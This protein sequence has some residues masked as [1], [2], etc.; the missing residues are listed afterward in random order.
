MANIVDLDVTDNQHRDFG[1]LLHAMTQRGSHARQQ[2]A[3]AERLV[4]IIIRAE[5]ES[6]DFFRFAIARGQ[7]DDRDVGPFADASDHVLAVAVRQAEVEHDD[8]GRVALRF[9]GPSDT[10]PAAVIDRNLLPAQA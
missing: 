3:D 2:L 7:H 8:V 9:A 4:D 10:V 5:V 1:M 6:R